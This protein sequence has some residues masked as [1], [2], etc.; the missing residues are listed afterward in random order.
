MVVTREE[1]LGK[2]KESKGGKIYGDT[3]DQTSDGGH[4]TEY[5]PM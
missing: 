4:T 2:G 3:G 1:G 5:I